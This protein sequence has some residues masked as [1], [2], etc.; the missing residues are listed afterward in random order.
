MH[1]YILGQV[2][3]TSLSLKSICC[4]NDNILVLLLAYFPLYIFFVMSAE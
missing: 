4:I 2:P 1:S 3:F